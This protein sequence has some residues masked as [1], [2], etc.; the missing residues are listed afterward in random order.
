MLPFVFK[1]SYHLSN[2]H[3]WFL[4]FWLFHVFCLVSI[5]NFLLPHFQ[6]RPLGW[7][8]PKTLHE[9]SF[10]NCFQSEFE[11]EVLT[12][13]EEKQLRNRI[14]AGLN[15]PSLTPAQRLF[16]CHWIESLT[17]VGIFRLDQHRSLFFRKFDWLIIQCFY[18]ILAVF[19]LWNSQRGVGEVLWV[20][21][22]ETM[23]R[24]NFP[25]NDKINY[26]ADCQILHWPELIALLYI[27]WYA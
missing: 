2:Y 1:I 17:N 8:H 6:L 15:H 16:Y 24:S 27:I 9:I 3:A 7:F 26:L 18:A 4:T 11:K 10:W 13:G 25:W 22:W 23:I 21:Q 12:D 20:L 14:L 19:Q 5:Y